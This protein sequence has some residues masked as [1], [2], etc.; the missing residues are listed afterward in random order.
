MKRILGLILLALTVACTVPPPRPV[1]QPRQTLVVTLVDDVELKPVVGTVTLDERPAPI[2]RETDGEGRAEFNVAPGPRGLLA[3]A[4]D[5][6][7]LRV[8]GVDNRLNA[9][10]SRENF[11]SVALHRKPPPVVRLPPLSDDA[12]PNANFGSMVDEHGRL[13]LSWFYPLLDAETQ[14]EWERRWKAEGLN[15][16]VLCPVMQYRDYWVGR[17]D[18]RD[19]PARFAAVVKQL[20]DRGFYVW[21]MMTSGD[22][23]TA[24][25]FKQYWPGLAAPLRPLNDWL[26]VAPGFES[27]GRD[28]GHSAAETSLGLYTLKALFARALIAIEFTPTRWTCA[29]YPL[30][31]DDPWGGCEECFGWSHGGELVDIVAYETDHGDNVLRDLSPLER[32]Q[33]TDQVNAELAD[34]GRQPYNIFGG[35]WPIRDFM[36]RWQE[37]AL[38][39]GCGVNGWRRMRFVSFF[40]STTMDQF[41][42]RTTPAEANHVAALAKQ[43]VDQEANCGFRLIYGSGLPR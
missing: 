34:R 17:D 8:E 25:D 5:F 10:G 16:V 7:C 41:Q 2:V 9:G 18:W 3:C 21:I 22:G 37:G 30:Q 38:R 35:L 14:A 12:R 43:V 39:Y 20:V 15:T 23:G 33:R 11:E 36:D 4:P 26:I 19:Q 42:R 13:M 24:A 31:I 32:R 40:E 28:A 6:E 29:S 1:V 27:C